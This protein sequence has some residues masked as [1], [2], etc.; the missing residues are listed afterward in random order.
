MRYNLFINQVKVMEWGL[1]LAQA[2]VFSVLNEA[3]SWASSTIFD[4]EVYY[5]FS[6]SK[7][8]KELPVVTDKPDTIKRHLAA[9]EKLGLIRRKTVVEGNNT[10][11]YIAITEKGKQWNAAPDASDVGSS[12]DGKNIPPRETSEND[13]G[14]NLSEA[15]NI[16]P[17]LGINIPNPREKNP[18][19]TN[20]N[21][22]LT[23]DPKDHLSD[24]VES[25]ETAP[26]VPVEK[27]DAKAKREL[28]AEAFEHVW[29]GYG[30]RG[31]KK[32]AETKFLKLKLPDDRDQAVAFLQN[33]I[34]KAKQWGALYAQHPS[35]IRFQPHCVRWINE[36]KWNDEQLPVL[37]TAPTQSTTGGHHHA[38]RKL[39]AAE[40]AIADANE[41]LSQQRADQPEPTG[42]YQDVCGEYLGRD[43]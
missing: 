31:S 34:A 37:N 7:L 39:S 3:H 15:G 22:P 12:G 30:R 21:N 28:L 35:E 33:I 41:L 27:F 29:V 42:G 40:R 9:L 32:P 10:Y 8:I 1:N 36:E 13:D 43:E 25:N 17:S 18:A 19:N 16:S 14:K 20:T 2:S 23:N 38:T 5:W 26:V 4:G 24:S 6:K 11:N